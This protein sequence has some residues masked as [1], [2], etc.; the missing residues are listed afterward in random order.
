[1]Y[2]WLWLRCNT[3]TKLLRGF[4]KSWLRLKGTLLIHSNSITCNTI[5]MWILIAITLRWWKLPWWHWWGMIRL[6]PRFY[7]SK[8]QN[9]STFQSFLT[10]FF[11]KFRIFG[12]S[13]QTSAIHGK[14]NLTSWYS[15]STWICTS[16][17]VLQH[18]RTYTWGNCAG[19]KHNSAKVVW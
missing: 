8:S 14:S 4:R 5:T 13:D 19:I 15:Y 9:L 17:Y 16:G 12:F 18:H 11:T 3:S 1:M 6:N 10:H 2:G 7:H